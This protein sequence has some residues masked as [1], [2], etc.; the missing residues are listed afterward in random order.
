MAVAAPVRR[1]PRSSKPLASAAAGRDQQQDRHIRLRR[2]ARSRK[3]FVRHKNKVAVFNRISGDSVVNKSTLSLG[4]SVPSPPDPKPVPPATIH[5]A[6]DVPAEPG[7]AEPGPT[8]MTQL[9]IS[10]TPDGAVS[11]S[12]ATPWGALPLRWEPPP[13]STKSPGRKVASNLGSG[14]LLSR[15]AKSR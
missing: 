12:T 4:G 1:P 13:L 5:A 10:S 15:P 8:T 3:S 6:A 2:G 7:S 14:R 9:Q 11:K